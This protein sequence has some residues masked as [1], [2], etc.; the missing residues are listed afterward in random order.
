M[1]RFSATIVRVIDGDTIVCNI[2]L[3]FNIQVVA[4][5]RVAGINC[6]EIGTSEGKF[7]KQAAQRLLPK[8]MMVEVVTAQRAF[9]KYGRILAGI[10]LDNGV[11]DYAD[12]MV[13][14]GYATPYMVA[15]QPML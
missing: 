9:D 13:T 8:D 14:S 10:L 2:Q 15:F 6:P 12:H 7:A 5:V 4:P 3:G 11:T 1:H